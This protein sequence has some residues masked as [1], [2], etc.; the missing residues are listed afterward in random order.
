MGTWSVGNGSLIIAAFVT[1]IGLAAHNSLQAY[2]SAIIM[3]LNPLCV[4]VC[5]PL[6]LVKAGICFEF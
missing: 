6:E 2:C 5:V 1:V 3:D 4:R